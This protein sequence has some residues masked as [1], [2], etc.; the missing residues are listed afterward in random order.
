MS[1]TYYSPSGNPEVW[2]E[3]P[4]GYLTV[5]EWIASLPPPP[6]PTVDEK[7][8]QID[9][10]TSAMIMR[11]F[12]FIVN[13]NKYRFSYDQFDQQN[14]SDSA[15]VAQMVL[16]GVQGLPPDITWNAWELEIDPESGQFVDRILH[17]LTLT[18]NDFLVLYTQGALTHKITQMEIGSQKKAALME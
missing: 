11:G 16:A 15:I 9:A 6:E 13:G 10:H 5:E 2:D 17:R 8:A 3:K 14:F 12:D 18:W 4:S 7:I 1:N